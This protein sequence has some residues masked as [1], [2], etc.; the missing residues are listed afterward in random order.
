MVRVKVSVDEYL[1]VC[2]TVAVTAGVSGIVADRVRTRDSVW[3]M[4]PV[5][6][7]DTE[8]VTVADCRVGVSRSVNDRLLVMASVEV[9]ETARRTLW[10]SCSVMVGSVGVLLAPVAVSAS[11]DVLVHVAVGFVI[12]VREAKARLSNDSDSVSVL[13]ASWCV[14]EDDLDRVSRWLESVNESDAVALID[15]LKVFVKDTVKD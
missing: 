11:V 9:G 4:S 6:D 14:N 15:P 1:S 13:V 3:V 5:M 12:A 2:E 8:S 10:V 7:R